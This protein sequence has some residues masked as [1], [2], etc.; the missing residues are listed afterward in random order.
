MLI[1]LPR[2]LTGMRKLEQEI[3]PTVVSKWLRNMTNRSVG[4]ARKP[5]VALATTV[6]VPSL[7]GLG[8][9]CCLGSNWSGATT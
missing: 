2:K 5:L 8:R 6:T 7:A 4:P 1:A 3:S 9:W